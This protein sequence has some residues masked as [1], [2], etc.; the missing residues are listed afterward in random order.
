MFR[1]KICGVKTG[2]DVSFAAQAGADAIGLNFY[3]PSPRSLS[4]DEAQQV[5][6]AA[7]GRFTLVGVFVNETVDRVVGISEQVGLNCIQLHGDE[8]LSFVDEIRK[9][10]SLP[11]IRAIR[12]ADEAGAPGNIPLW[13]EKVDGLL[14][15]AAVP[16]AYGGTGKT[17]DFETA[18]KICRSVDKPVILA[19][20]LT[21][22]NVAEAIAAVK[23]HGVDTASG[24]ESAPGKKDADL[25]VQFVK[26]ARTALEQL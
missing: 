17:V 24:V 4:I 1:T 18:N 10:S 21:P 8:P 23:P 26:E 9:Q 3:P 7:N 11:I 20:G 22:S 2:T 12:I 6:I 19:G 13:S 16:N 25:V 15:D 14:C 5:R